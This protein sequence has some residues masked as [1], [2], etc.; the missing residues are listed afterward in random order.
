[1]KDYTIKDCIVKIGQLIRR[2]SLRKSLT[3][4]LLIAVII[5]CS[6]NARSSRGAPK[7][8]GN[9]SVKLIWDVPQKRTDGSALINIKGYKIYYGTA[10]GMYTRAVAVPL[11]EPSLSCGDIESTVKKKPD[12]KQCM[13]AVQGLGNGVY[14]FAVTVYDD[15]GNESNLSNEIS[16]KLKVN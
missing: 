8:D 13:Y 12:K 16:K 11:T 4:L 15:R 5:P 7:A 10:S 3:E 2:V 6:C 14:Y 1:M 9:Y